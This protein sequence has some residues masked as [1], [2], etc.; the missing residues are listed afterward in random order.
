[1]IQYNLWR[2]PVG[3]YTRMYVT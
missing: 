3:K 2:W 1:M